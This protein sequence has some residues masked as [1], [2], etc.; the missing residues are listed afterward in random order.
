M[1]VCEKIKIKKRLNLFRDIDKKKNYDKI[2]S[3]LKIR[4]SDFMIKKGKTLIGTLVAMCFLTSAAAVGGLFAV[5]EEQTNERPQSAVYNLRDSVVAS[6][7]AYKADSS[8]GVK[9]DYPMA[10]IEFYAGTVERAQPLAPHAEWPE[11]SFN[12]EDKS[13][14]SD[15]NDFVQ[16]GQSFLRSRDYCQAVIKLTAKKDSLLTV[17]NTAALTTWAKEFYFDSYVE[18]SGELLW[19]D[20]VCTGAV[21]TPNGGNID[22]AAGALSTSAHLSAGDSLYYVGR[23]SWGQIDNLVLSFSFDEAAY[24][25]EWKPEAYTEGE[26][27]SISYADLVS[28]AVARGGKRVQSGLY[29]MSVYGGALDDKIPYDVVKGSGLKEGGDELSYGGWK[30]GTFNEISGRIVRWATYGNNI[31][32]FEA[33]ENVLLKMAFDGINTWSENMSCAAYAESEGKRVLLSEKKIKANAESVEFLQNIHLKKGDKAYF[34]ISGIDVLNV[35]G[36]I[37]F[38]KSEYDETS[39]PDYDAGL[40]EAVSEFQKTFT[41]DFGASIRK[42]E[43]S[44]LRFSVSGDREKYDVLLV[45]LADYGVVEYSFGTVIVPASYIDEGREVLPGG[46][47]ILTIKAENGWNNTEEKI[48]YKASIVNIKESNYERKFVAL[49]YFTY[50]YRNETK[51]VWA[52]RGDNARSVYEVAVAAKEHGEESAFIDEIISYVENHKTEE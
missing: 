29:N 41:N 40:T 7:N 4:R 33:K 5:A 38:V 20:S 11:W 44:G 50:Q 19:T 26:S 36:S 23:A 14:D 49:G 48:N 8:S 46:E 28:D 10:D 2:K 3:L 42:N 37:S 1:V 47:G 25:S 39:R 17:S 34:V 52:E 32:E 9:A 43:P 24:D 22:L 12:P 45:A 16:I 30:D 15:W 27:V 51:V 18:K 13:D 35:G 6:W 21:G 31:L